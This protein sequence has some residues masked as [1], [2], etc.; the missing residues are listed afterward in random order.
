MTKRSAVYMLLDLIV[1]VGAFLLMIKLKP[2]SANYI[3]S[4]YLSSF[5][6]FTCI[7][8]VISVLVKKYAYYEFENNT[9][10]LRQVVISNIIALGIVT[11]L[12]YLFRIDYYSRL[13]VFGTIAITTIIEVLIGNLLFYMAKAKVYD[14]DTEVKQRNGKRLIKNTI[15]ALSKTKKRKP[16][17]KL[18]EEAILVEIKEDAFEFIFE[19][20]NVDSSQTLIVSTTSAFNIEAQLNDRFESVVNLRR[21]NDIRFIN[22]FFEAVNRKLDDGGLYIDFVETKNLRKKRILHKYPPVLNYIF[23]TVDFIV[24]RVFPKFVITKKIY[25]FLTRG[26]NRVITKA[27]T[28][29]RLYSCGFEVISE[30][31]IDNHLFFVARKIREPLYPKNPTYGPF[32]KLNRVGKD[33]KMIRVYKLRTM[34][35]YAEYLQDYIYKKEGLEEGGKFRKDFRVSTVG[36]ILRTFWIDELPMLANFIRGDLKIVGVRPISKHY[37]SLYSKQHQKRRIKYKPGIIPPFYVHKPDT[38]DQIMASE[39]K[40]MDSYDK[41]PVR[42][43]IVYFF[44]A[45]YNIIFKRYRSQ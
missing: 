24:K 11:T 45:I 44:S 25:F 3:H 26:Q 10:V 15:T 4:K 12:M 23:Y 37:F 17:F 22:K 20:A 43:D 29:G 7:W 28:F 19:Y 30:K 1:L 27:E 38:L 41:H 35:P 39:R 40:Y 34:H 8:I 2:G 42:T 36:K 6:S 5:L 16:G 18:R 14:Q 21:I 32:I 13:L 9:Q 31:F 33:G